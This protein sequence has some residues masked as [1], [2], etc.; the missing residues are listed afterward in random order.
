[1]QNKPDVMALFK[2]EIILNVPGHERSEGIFV[3]ITHDS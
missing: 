1:M 2:F 3:K